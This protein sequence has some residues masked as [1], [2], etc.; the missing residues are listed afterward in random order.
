MCISNATY[1]RQIKP[2]S[3]LPKESDN[4]KSTEIH[5]PQLNHAIKCNAIR[6]RLLE[7][8]QQS[9][10]GACRQDEKRRRRGRGKHRLCTFF[11]NQTTVP[12]PHPTLHKKPFLP[13]NIDAPLS[14]SR[15]SIS[16]RNETFKPA[17]NLQSVAF[18]SPRSSQSLGALK[19][20]CRDV[21]DA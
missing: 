15:V 12:S 14:S 17:I 10:L 20:L 3:L 6:H 9:E 5:L 2:F 16:V 19:S 4:P 21:K 18:F 1:Q 13:A 8:L 7:G 11:N